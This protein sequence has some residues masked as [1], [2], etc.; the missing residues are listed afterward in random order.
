MLPAAL[1][2]TEIFSRVAAELDMDPVELALKNDGVE[3]KGP[4]LLDEEKEKLGFQ[5]RDSLRECVEMGK[6]A[7]GWD[8]KRHAWVARDQI[9]T[10]RDVENTSELVGLE[11]YIKTIPYRQKF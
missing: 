7:I 11:G 1:G 2:I 6:A 10:E 5:K 4:S 8:G 3:G 9:L